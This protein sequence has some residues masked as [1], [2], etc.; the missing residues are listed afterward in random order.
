M[1]TGNTVID[2]LLL[3]MKDRLPPLQEPEQAYGSAAEI[4]E[5]PETPVVLVT[6]HRRESFGKGFEQICTALRELA[7][8]HPHVQIYPV[9][10]NSKGARA[11]AP[12][13]CR[14]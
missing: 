13:A 9:H 2:A 4:F 6:G 11:G 14:D 7:Q 1:T 8:K 5:N 3:W 12:A 10:L